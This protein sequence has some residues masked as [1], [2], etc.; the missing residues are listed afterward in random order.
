VVDIDGEEKTLSQD[1]SFKVGS[2]F[3]GAV[4]EFFS[5]SFD[6]HCVGGFDPLEVECKSAKY[7]TENWWMSGL[8]PPNSTSNFEYINNRVH[9]IAEAMTDRMRAGRSILQT[10]HDAKG[11]MT[12]RAICTHFS[13][14]WLL[15]PVGLLVLAA[16]VLSITMAI[17]AI[18]KS[19]QPIWKSSILPALYASPSSEL[20]NNSGRIDYIEKDAHRWLARLQRKEDSW[21]FVLTPRETSTEATP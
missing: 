5:G 1:C 11:V 9:M 2:T 21:E 6:G 17:T 7:G 15:L 8:Y 13:W 3:I 10:H 19:E 20:E 14:P 16:V 18:T 12:E 4:I